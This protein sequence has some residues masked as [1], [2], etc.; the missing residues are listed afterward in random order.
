MESWSICTSLPP[1]HAF[2][3][4][5]GRF[6]RISPSDGLVKVYLPYLQLPST[7]G[8]HP[9]PGVPVNVIMVECL[10]HRPCEAAHHIGRLK[11]S[12]GL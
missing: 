7:T 1:F 10:Y 12:Q 2:V 6:K 8:R 9:A 11:Q 5:P 3:V 4:R